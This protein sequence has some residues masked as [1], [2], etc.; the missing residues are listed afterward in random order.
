MASGLFNFSPNLAVLMRSRSFMG[1]VDIVLC[2][3]CHDISGIIAVQHKQFNF[4]RPGTKLAAFALP[5]L[6]AWPVLAGAISQPPDP[7]LDSGPTDACAAGVDYAP[8][9]DVSGNPVVPA[10][11]ASRPV[12]L[13]DTIAIP[14]ARN[15]SQATGPRPNPA[16]GRRGGAPI[17]DNA[18]IR[19]SAYVALDGRKL[20]PLLNPPPCK[21]VR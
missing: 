10:D 13:P 21:A 8:G 16:P 1:W 17:P 3:C 4:V 2:G 14:I 12:P 15:R 9:I 18:S 20:E 19:D 7:L 6:M 11:V 5:L